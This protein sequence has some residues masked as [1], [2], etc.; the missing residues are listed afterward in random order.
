MISL[1]LDEDR[2]WDH[3]L[4]DYLKNSAHTRSLAPL[5]NDESPE[6]IRLKD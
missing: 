4:A 3:H 6:S 5:L 2:K 1:G